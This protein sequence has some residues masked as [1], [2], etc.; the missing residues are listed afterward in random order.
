MTY[1]T[2]SEMGLRRRATKALSRTYE[3]FLRLVTQ[4]YIQAR[5]RA[6]AS[7]LSGTS[8]DDASSA[9]PGGVPNT[10]RKCGNP[11][12]KTTYSL[13]TVLPVMQEGTPRRG[14]DAEFGFPRSL[15]GLTF[16]ISAQVKFLSA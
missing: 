6:G 4:G 8:V 10:G 11:L 1:S 13:S 5:G 12:S 2:C 9:A 15:I 16:S 3:F 14:S 7:G